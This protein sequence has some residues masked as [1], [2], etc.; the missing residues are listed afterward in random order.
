MRILLDTHTFLW[1]LEDS[2]KLSETAKQEILNSNNICFI[3]M[4]SLWEISIKYKL[5]KLRLEIPFSELENE[6]N[7]NF[8]QILPIEF[9]HLEGLLKIGEIHRDPFDRLIISQA[10]AENLTVISKDENF[11]KYPEVEVLW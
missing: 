10:K 6:I 5:Q 4:A 9:T 8:Y 1:F 11:R 2:P 3:S 7:K